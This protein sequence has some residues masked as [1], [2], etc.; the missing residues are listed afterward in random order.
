MFYVY[1]K[2]LNGRNDFYHLARMLDERGYSNQVEYFQG[3]EKIHPHL[4]F[5]DEGDAVAYCLTN[6]C[7]MSTYMPVKEDSIYD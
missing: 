6:G 1:I 4:K 3:D 7:T 2:R 5:I